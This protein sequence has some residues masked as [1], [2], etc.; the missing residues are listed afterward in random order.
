MLHVS[1]PPEPPRAA[2]M[3]ARSQQGSAPLSPACQWCR[4]VVAPTSHQR[5]DSACR[6]LWSSLTVM[7]L[8]SLRRPRSS[9]TAVTVVAA[10][11]KRWYRLASGQR[12]AEA[13]AGLDAQIQPMNQELQRRRGGPPYPAVAGIA[14]EQWHKEVIK[15]AVVEQG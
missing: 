11:P 5:S 10:P 8:E 2:C 7:I 9:A 4:L 14:G 12:K 1:M 15:R 3:H 13:I 6:V